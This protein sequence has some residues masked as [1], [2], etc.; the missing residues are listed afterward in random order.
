MLTP[1]LRCVVGS[2]RALIVFFLAHAFTD[3]WLAAPAARQAR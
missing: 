1:G 3:P 2:V